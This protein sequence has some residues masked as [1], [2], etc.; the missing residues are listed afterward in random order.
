MA[1]EWA[2]GQAMSPEQA[3]GAA[4]ASLEPADKGSRAAGAAP[5]G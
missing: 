3:T 4:L 1:A 2:E 5:K